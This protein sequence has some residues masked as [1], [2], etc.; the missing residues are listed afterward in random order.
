MQT[1]FIIVASCDDIIVFYVGP[2]TWSESFLEAKTM[3]RP[4]AVAILQTTHPTW[5]ELFNFQIIPVYRA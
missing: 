1:E 4:D 2:T 3:P 5:K